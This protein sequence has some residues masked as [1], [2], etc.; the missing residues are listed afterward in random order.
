[1][2]GSEP[3]LTSDSSRTDPSDTIPVPERVRA[4]LLS[5]WVPFVLVVL[6]YV[7]VIHI[8]AAV[9]LGD[10]ARFVG[11]LAVWVTFPGTV[12]W[13]L[14]DPRGSRAGGSAGGRRHLGEDLLIGSLVGYVLEFP[15]YLAFLALGH[16][17]G[18]L[19]WPL[20]P[21]ALLISPLGRTARHLGSGRLP[22]WWSWSA[23]VAGL[24]LVSWFGHYLWRVSSVQP[25]ALRA[26]YVDEPYHLALASGLK[27]FF[28]PRVTYVADT[29]LNYHYLAHVH[30]AASSWVTGIEP[31]VLL[32]AVALP[33]LVIIAVVAAAFVVVRLS[34]ALWTGLVLFATVLIG[35]ASFG[36]W[37]SG[38][39][40]GLISTRLIASPSAGFVNA[41]LLLGVLLCLELLT[42]PRRA[43]AATALV[44][45]VFVA[46]AGAKSTS[47]PT[48]L[49]GLAAAT[50]ITSVAARKVNL[51]AGVLTVGA[52]IAFEVAKIIF[53]GPGSHG[54]ALD[55]LALSTS[56]LTSFPGLADPGGTM[57][58]GVRAIVAT[59][60]LAY[61]TLGIAG[62]ALL[63]R[64]GW[65][66][67]AN[68]FLVVTCAAGLG[69]G[70]TFHQ[71]SF[72]EYYFIYVVA[73]P[74]MV[75]ATLGIHQIVEGP[76][77]ARFVGPGLAAL[78]IGMLGTWAFHEFTLHAAPHNPQGSPASLA[79]RLFALPE[80]LWLIFVLVLVGLVLGGRRLLVRGRPA[81]PGVSLLV[82]A[83]TFAGFGTGPFIRTVVPGVLSDPLARP[84]ASTN[85]T[86][87]GHGGIGAARWLRAHSATDDLLATNVHCQRAQPVQCVPRSFWIAAYAERQVLVEG[88]SYVSRWSVG[89]HPPADENVTVGPFW[90][91]VRLRNNDA[92]FNHPSPSTIGLLSRRYH[93]RWL[94]VD[95][96]FPADVAGLEKYAALAYQ[97]G[98]Y[99]VLK[100][101]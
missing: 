85:P 84:V 55:P 98:R 66:N 29:P 88:W 12:I 68:V 64:R 93:V 87:I 73:L 8:S 70:L 18:Y 101:G 19:L 51:R 36:G 15:I 23:G 78:A 49:A 95:T 82:V 56:R 61:L 32:R 50:V 22:L 38:A 90:D 77:V 20:M 91:P 76:H 37:T 3:A 100:L 99:L 60:M 80:A 81:L 46:M 2:S 92:A 57:S 72:S 7:G 35:P 24:Y 59:F 44:F 94:F 74:M 89:E 48:V 71:S 33:A 11:Y 40:E 5:G 39:G 4:V 41:A 9:S 47:L 62:L 75:A 25:N 63:S 96:R 67:P 10:A 86:Q 14:V 1:M 52:G 54:L 83:A 79:L 43:Y 27:H 58:F 30:V 69:A 97:Q 6:G 53:F 16:P 21:L 26:P 65:A 17:H 34:G 13:R 42:L 45:V 28:P 31:I